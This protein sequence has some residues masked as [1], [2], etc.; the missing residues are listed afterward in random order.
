MNFSDDIIEF[1]VVVGI[2]Y[3]S[4]DHLV[5]LLGSVDLVFACQ[6]EKLKFDVGSC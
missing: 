1:R 5:D 2:G 3:F 4:R 6:E